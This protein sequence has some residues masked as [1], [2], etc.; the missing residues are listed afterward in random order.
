[1][2][3]RAQK[4]PVLGRIWWD[5]RLDSWESEVELLP[6]CPIR[7]AIVAEADWQD[8]DPK[9]LFGAGAE[10]LDWA[11]E[12]ERRVRERI[13]DD[14]LDV[15][16]NSW[17]DDDPAEGPLPMGRAEFLAN[18]RPSGISLHHDGSSTWDYSC[19]ELFAGHGIWLMLDRDRKFI[20]KA[21]LVG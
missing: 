2:S 9:E 18:I 17:A 11:R 21:S 16:N 1:M 10:Y 5:D 15:Y 6:G 13:A 20:G 19:G 4:H 3:K 7:F 8:K 12:A 14:L